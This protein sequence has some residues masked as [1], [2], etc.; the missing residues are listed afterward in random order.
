MSTPADHSDV[1]L[2]FLRQQLAKLSEEVQTK[3]S[4]IETI[5]TLQTEVM[6]M[7]DAALKRLEVCC[8]YFL[9]PSL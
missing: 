9:Y 8:F 4:E 6:I 1:E 7:R 5:N 3:K 2:S